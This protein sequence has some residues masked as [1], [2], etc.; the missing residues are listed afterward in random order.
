MKICRDEEKLS[1][2]GMSQNILLADKKFQ[3]VS[4]DEK[5][6]TNVNA[7]PVYALEIDLEQ[8]C[9]AEPRSPNPLQSHFL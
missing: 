6:S 7:E 9:P 4:P 8:L 1:G 5:L 2:L 3:N